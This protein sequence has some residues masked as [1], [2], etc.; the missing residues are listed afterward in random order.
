MSVYTPVTR[1]QLE[2][3]LTHYDV[4]QLR[5]YAGIRAGI[6]NT[7]Y[8]VTTEGGEWVLTLFETLGNR[9]L[10]WFLGL[11]DHLGGRN[12]PVPAPRADRNG[13]FLRNLNNRPAALVQRLRGRS[14]EAPSEPHC[15]AMGEMLARMHQAG[16]DYPGEH[17]DNPRG[18]AW[19]QA[20]AERLEP[21]LEHDDARLLA[22]ELGH[23]CRL[24][25]ASLPRGIIHG[26]L[27]L[28]NALFEEGH[29]T[30]IIDFYYACHDLLL[31]DL[32]VAVNDWCTDALGNVDS[33]LQA[34]LFHG[35][36]RHREPGPQESACWNSMLRAAALRFWLSRLHDSHFPRGGEITRIKDPE[37]F[38]RILMRRRDEPCRMP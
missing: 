3:F 19:Q 37:P 8:F 36:R 13:G 20:T 6:E 38:R 33:E 2:Q 12:L 17:R 15:E 35:Y 16:L 30:G 26:D 23:Q 29:L 31:Y 28:D 14:L 11:M 7:N 9:E 1:Q 25:T 32:A 22:D 18:L 10:P 4:G 21:F 5:E 24:E 34:A 27:F